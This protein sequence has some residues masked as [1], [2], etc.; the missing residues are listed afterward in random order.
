MLGRL[1]K[2]AYLFVLALMIVAYA[3]SAANNPAPQPEPIQPGE[4]WYC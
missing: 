3:A 4:V 1:A 2:A